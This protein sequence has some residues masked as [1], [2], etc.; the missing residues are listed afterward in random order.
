MASDASSDD[1]YREFRSDVER[2][3]REFARVRDLPPYI[4]GPHHLVY[5]SKVFKAYTDLWKFQ[6]SHRRELVA[7]GLRRWEIGE[8]ASRIGQLYYG[9]YMRTGEWRFLLG[10][11]VFYEAILE[12]GYFEK[13]EGKMQDPGLRFKELRFVARFLVVALLVNRAEA[14]K[15]LAERLKS[16]VDE[17]KAAYPET[18]FKEWKQILHELNRFLKADKEFENSR[19]L[20]YN[21]SFDSY[22]NSI[23]LIAPFYSKRVLRLRDAILTSYHRN[24][25]KFTELTIDTFRMLQCLE[26]E[27]SGSQP[28]SATKQPAENGALTDYSGVASG[29]IDISLA[30]DLADPSMPVNPRKAVI[31]H[32]TVSHV[33]SVIASVCEELPSDSVL[34]LYISASGDHSFGHKKIDNPWARKDTKPDTHACSGSPVWLGPRGNGGLNYLFP[35]D[36]VPFTR[37]PLFLIVDSENSHAF[38]VIHGAER[39]EPAAMLLSPSVSPSDLTSSGSLFTYFLTAPLQA[40]CHLVGLS[41]EFYASISSEVEQLLSS[42]LADI[43]EALCASKGMDRVWAQVLPDPFLRRLIL[44]FIFCRGVLLNYSKEKDS[45]HLPVCVP[46]LPEVVSP[47]SVRNHVFLLAD[48]LGVVERFPSFR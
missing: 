15:V 27:P 6:Q 41:S 24:E 2:A 44:R 3:D 14:V 26:Y 46:S 30:S 20:R 12:R 35:E 7:S 10:A 48:K 39:G 23:P 16:L 9:Q 11:Y 22:P 45:A 32:P 34:L 1:T 37:S 4:R 40:F 43:E 36:L 28:S 19:S 29:L 33:I 17:S 21:L 8:L 25:I 31:Y 47:T 13:S 18:S 38:K 42:S 5:Q